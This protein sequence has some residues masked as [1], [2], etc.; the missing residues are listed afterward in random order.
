MTWRVDRETAVLLGS[1]ARALLLQVAHP[2][3]A[4]A[5]ADHSRYRSDPLGRLRD[6]LDAIYGFSFADRSGVERILSQIHH[7]HT[8]VSGRTPDG[9]PYSALDPHLLLWVYAT[10]I[11][12]SLLAYETFVA[13]L[14]AGERE[15]YY[16]EL[17]SAGPLWGIR[18][19][20]FPDSLVGLRAWM[21]D[22]VASGEV[23]V[24]PQGRHVGRFILE[25]RVWWMPRPA[26]VLLRQGTIWLLPP[27]LR[28]GF[29]YTW[30]PRRERGMRR[31][32]ACSRAIVPRLPHLARDL[33]IARA[34]EARV[35]LVAARAAPDPAGS[36]E[37]SHLRRP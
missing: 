17:R 13:K 30:G 16:A 31:L 33:P 20:D 15:A 19:A 32:A 12:S 14:S 37:G 7:L 29:G 11:D 26:E 21:G 6:T 22:L 28:A 18:A 36:A 35:R 2:K 4:A 25:P 9:K 23:R 24:S 10:L 27:V 5:V 1:G 34:A 8:R 3:V